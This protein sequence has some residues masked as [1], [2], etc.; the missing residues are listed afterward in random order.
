[1][2]AETPGQ[3]NY[4]AISRAFGTPKPTLAMSYRPEL[5][6]LR[7]FPALMGY[8]SRILAESW[9]SNTLY[10]AALADQIRMPPAQLNLAVPEWTKLAVEQVFASNLEDWPAVLSSLHHIGDDARRQWRQREAAEQKASLALAGR[11]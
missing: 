10:W 4:A 5:L 8:S 1:M 2:S 3:V 7:T 11:E 6:F 9:E